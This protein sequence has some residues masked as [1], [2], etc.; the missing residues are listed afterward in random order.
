MLEELDFMPT[1]KFADGAEIYEHCRRI[2]KHFGLYDAAI[3]NT[4]RYE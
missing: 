4:Q 3:S 1:K 2:G